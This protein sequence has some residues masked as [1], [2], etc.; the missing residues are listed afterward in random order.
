MLSMI[1]LEKLANVLALR[2]G[3]AVCAIKFD[4]SIYFVAISEESTN[5]YIYICENLP[6]SN[7]QLRC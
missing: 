7:Y 4:W 6:G 5:I 2:C 1:L 3:F